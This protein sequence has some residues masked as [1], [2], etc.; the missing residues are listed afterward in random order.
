MSHKLETAKFLP[1]EALIG[2]QEDGLWRGVN[3]RRKSGEPIGAHVMQRTALPKR[4]FDNASFA[5]RS[6]IIYC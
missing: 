1:A 2:R 5:K 3:E 6:W 4:P